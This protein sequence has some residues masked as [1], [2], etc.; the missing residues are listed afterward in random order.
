MSQVPFGSVVRHGFRLLSL[1]VLAFAISGIQLTAQVS[2]ARFEGTIV[3]AA[4]S[5]VPGAIVSATNTKTGISLTATTTSEGYFVLPSLQPSFYNISVEAKGFRKAEIKDLELNAAATVRQTIKLE[6]GNVTETITVE[7][8]AVRV[9]TAD[10]QLSKTV[11]MKEIDTLPQLGRNPLA[12]LNFSAGVSG[13]SATDS[14]ARVNGLRQGSNN[15]RLDGID[16]NDAVTGR[17]GLSLTAFNTDS[18][19]EFRFVTNSG[20]AEY[21]RNAGGQIEVITRGGTNKLKGSVFEYLRNTNLNANNYFNNQSRTPIP[22]LIQN[23]YGGAIGGKIIRDKLFFFGN[24]QGRRTITDTIRNRTVFTDSARR[25]VFSWREP[26]TGAL[27]TFDIVAADP[28]KRGLDKRT[29]A[30]IALTPLPNNFDIGDGLNTAGFRF[31]SPSG[32]REEQGTGKIDYNIT[33]NHHLFFR[34]SRQYNTSLDALN[35]ADAQF[36]G[37]PSGTQGGDRWGYSIGSDWTLTPTWVSELRFGYQSASVNFLRP[38]RGTA[39]ALTYNSITNPINTAFGQGRN[40]PVYDFTANFTNLRGKHT[41]KFGYN[42]RRT[43]QDGYNDAGAYPDYSLAVANGATVPTT[44]GPN[45]AAVISSADR[46]RFENQYNDLLGRIS[47]ISATF[48]SDLKTFQPAGTSRIRSTRFVDYGLFVQDDWRITKRLV[49][50]LGLRWDLLTSPNELNGFQGAFDQIG[51]ISP[52]ARIANLT[53]QQ[54]GQFYANDTNNFGPRFGFAYDVFGNGKTA[55]RGAFGVYYDRIIGASSNLVDGNTP[56]FAQTVQVFPNSS[57]ASDIRFSDNAALPSAPASVP[58]TLPTNRNT[59]AVAFNPNLATP[60]V[61]HAS[62]NIQQELARNLILEVGYV[63]TRGIKLF[64]WLNLN[65]PR[66]DGDFANAFRELQAFQANSANVPSPGNTL[67]RIFGTPQQAVTS[68]GATALTQG[69]LGTAAD[70][71]DRVNFS[72]Y[73]AA[74]VD[75]FYLRNFPQFNQFYYGDNVGR[76]YYDSLQVSLRRVAGDLRYQANYTF[77]KNL[78]NFSAEGNGVTNPVSNYNL[79]LNRSRADFDRPHILNFQGVWTLPIGKNKLLL[80]NASPWLNRFIGG[81]DIGA[82]G[83]IQSGTLFSV[84]SGRRTTGA[85][86]SS[87][88]NLTLANTNIGKIIKNPNGV[89]TYFTPQEAAGF[90]FPGANQ[91]GNTGRNAFR[92]PRYF[93]T[94]VSLVKRFPLWGE[95][96]SVTFRAEAYN[97]FNNVNFGGVGASL[98][99]PTTLGRL[100]SAADSRTM[101]LALR[102][103]F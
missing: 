71:V 58:T 10:A 102:F 70:T 76:S 3:D 26:G 18:V 38:D 35:S 84:T 66:T 100:T 31:N 7:A 99:T 25:G 43:T 17:L 12:L 6:V 72:R 94:D 2:N 39:A 13:G 67:V 75:Q 19:E 47:S 42:V 41:I 59:S 98:L 40:S 51:S 53:I 69:L 52:T 92:G 80:G 97:V 50:N 90:T 15:L 83:V 103:D 37:R 44:I 86:L 82:I 60:Y 87:Y 29:A 96:H 5:V 77:S 34:Y 55:I 63:G 36:P 57:G 49:L 22:R 16:A 1:L 88:A 45:G 89:V 79:R 85:D 56:G 27:R 73:A 20:K 54:S 32:S 33:E 101:Q 95:G 23:I 24:Y 9:Q 28:L 93:N 65:Q 62:L 64:N 48:Y 61:L 11:N 81:W 4:G 30:D 8:T 21:G 74:G 68:I 91:L 78:D 46:Q 14:F